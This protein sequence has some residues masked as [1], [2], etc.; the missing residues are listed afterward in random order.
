MATLRNAEGIIIDSSIDLILIPDD[1]GAQTSTEDIANPIPTPTLTAAYDDLEC[2][3]RETAREVG[4]VVDVIDGRTIDVKLEDGSIVRVRYLGIA[5]IVEGQPLFEQSVEINRELVLDKMVTLVK[6]PEVEEPEDFLL[7]YVFVGDTFVNLELIADGFAILDS[8][9]SCVGVFEIKTVGAYEGDRGFTT[10]DDRRFGNPFLETPPAEIYDGEFTVRITKVFN[11]GE[12]GAQEPDEYVE[13]RN[14]GIEAI[15]L[16]GWTLSDEQNHIFTFPDFT[17]IPE[18]SCR[19]YT[20]EEHSDW[21]G[22]NYESSQPIWGNK[23]DC[24]TLRDS[25]GLFVGR[26]CY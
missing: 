12:K 24:A 2:I 17:F 13:I 16:K 23:G 18:K 1:E 21:C 7:R 8:D 9:C 15:Q 3:P 5:T 19:I 4:R 14:D 22:F 6:D 26:S 11:D 20:N 10:V 25:E